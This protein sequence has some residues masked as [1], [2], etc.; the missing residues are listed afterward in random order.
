MTASG[1]YGL[2]RSLSNLLRHL[3]LRSL[4]R[5]AG[6]YTASCA[7][8][9][10][11]TYTA[12]CAIRHFDTYT[13]CCPIRHFDAVDLPIAGADRTGRCGMWELT[14]LCAG[15]PGQRKRCCRQIQ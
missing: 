11:D 7:I 5:P 10:F 9:H 8:R 15:L 3:T 6:Y 14:R 12:S 2:V 1:A 13:A 4:L